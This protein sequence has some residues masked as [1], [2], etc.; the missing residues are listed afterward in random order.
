MIHSARGRI[1]TGSEEWTRG[2]KRQY[3]DRE[4]GE[5]QRRVQ[6]SIA[7]VTHE[8]VETVLLAQCEH[9]HGAGTRGECEPSN[10][11]E[12]G[13]DEH[14]QRRRLGGAIH[15]RFWSRRGDVV[16]GHRQCSASDCERRCEHRVAHR[17]QESAA[18]ADQAEHEE[19]AKPGE[20]RIRAGR[21]AGPL[22]L[23]TNA[24]AD[25]PRQ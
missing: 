11:G 15:A 13:Q 25:Q 22:T 17:R 7:Q 21:V 2:Q 5:L 12:S 9:H 3:D 24:E 14:R 4:H 8:T 19:C 16:R 10:A 6:F 23:E 18:T 20:P 1:A